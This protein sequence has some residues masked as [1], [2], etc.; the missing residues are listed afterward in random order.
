MF[1]QF[2]R[3]RFHF[4]TRTHATRGKIAQQCSIMPVDTFSQIRSLLENQ[5]KTAC[6][7]FRHDANV[8]ARSRGTVVTGT[9]EKSLDDYKRTMATRSQRIRLSP[10]R[11]L[12]TTSD[13]RTLTLSSPTRGDFR[14][15]RNA[16]CTGVIASESLMRLLFSAEWEC[17]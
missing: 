9:P 10:A 6:D 4:F 14:W 2:L 7:T 16:A 15:M 12:Q 17:Q 5:H 1:Q 8:I 11:P 3:M 13:T